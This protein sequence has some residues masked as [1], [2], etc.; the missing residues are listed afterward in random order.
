MTQTEKEK[1]EKKAKNRKK[2]QKRNAITLLTGQA[3]LELL[4]QLQEKL[5]EYIQERKTKF[6]EQLENA[7]LA[8]IDEDSITIQ[9]SVFPMA[10][11]LDNAFEPII[12][13]PG[14]TPTYSPDKLSLLFDYFRYCVVKI[15]EHKPYAPT[16]EDFCRLVGMST[17]RFSDLKNSNSL[18]M[19]EVCFQIED[20]ISSFLSQAA[21]KGDIEQQYTMFL[22]RAT[23]GKSDQNITI[24]SNVQNNTVITDKELIELMNKYPG[25]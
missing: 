2:Q 16:K 9:N 24:N 22:Q 5:P 8:V 11:L 23:L 12:K 4:E 17:N 19:R 3:K 1:R 14:S 13:V 6:V 10:D 20:Y 15:N 7:G 21:I 18:E 25:I